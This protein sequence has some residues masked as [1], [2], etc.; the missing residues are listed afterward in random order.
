MGTLTAEECENLSAASV[1]SL[2]VGWG[3]SLTY[4]TGA[5][6]TAHDYPSLAAAT[7][8]LAVANKGIGGQ[9]STEIKDRCIA[10]TVLRGR[11]AWIWAGRNNIGSPTMIKADIATMAAW[12]I[13]GR[14]LVGSILTASNDGG[15]IAVIQTLNAELATLYGARYVDILGALQAANDGSA[16]DLADVAAGYTPRSL[17][18][19]G[20]VHLNDAG[21]AIVAATWISAHQA[22]GW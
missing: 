21:Y 5:S 17:R 11:A 3:D 1:Q 6:D 10:D 4:G 18:D 20:V 7:L 22:M 12:G 14:Y 2:I 9:T 19:G 8:G 15:N 16:N 13:S